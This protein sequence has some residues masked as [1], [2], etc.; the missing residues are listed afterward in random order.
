MGEKA[1]GLWDPSLQGMFINFLE[2]RAIRL[3]LLHFAK[4]LFCRNVGLRCDN[5]TALDYLV[6][7][8]VL[9][10]GF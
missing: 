7:E 3:A 5:T 10:P 8:G 1:S 9:T 4:L 2:L 6:N